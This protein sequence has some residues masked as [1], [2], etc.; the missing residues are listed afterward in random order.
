[1]IKTRSPIA[2][3]GT[4]SSNSAPK[5]AGELVEAGNGASKASAHELQAPDTGDAK[6]AASYAYRGAPTHPALVQ[7][8]RLL[9]R[10]AAREFDLQ[11]GEEDSDGLERREGML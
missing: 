7:L 4:T 8:A 6:T 1:M 3:C 11:C 2:A 9:G 10:R 5:S